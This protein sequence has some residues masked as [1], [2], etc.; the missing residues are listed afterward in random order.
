MKKFEDVKPELNKTLVEVKSELGISEQLDIV[1]KK[2]YQNNNMQQ[3]GTKKDNAV[4]IELTYLLL[5][6]PDIDMTDIVQVQKRV[7]EFIAI[8]HQAQRKLTVNGL[9]LALGINR[10]RLWE[11]INDIP[12]TNEYIPK[13]VSNFLKKVYEG[14]A[15][16]LEANIMEGKVNP[17]PGIF[18]AKNHFGYK[19]Q[20]DHVI[21]AKRQYD[22]DFNEDDIKNKYL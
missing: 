4:T 16:D 17:I 20:T 22:T 1:G 14:F 6:L 3:D 2:L 15:Y 10:V 13:E 9:A 19:D 12:K 5:Q 8:H 18:F 11:I 7:Q 21:E